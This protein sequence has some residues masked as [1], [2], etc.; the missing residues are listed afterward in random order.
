M[1]NWTALK[2]GD[3]MMEIFMAEQN[4]DQEYVSFWERIKINP[5]IWHCDDVI[6]DNFWVVAQHENYIIWYNDIEEGFCISKFKTEG[7]IQQY[8]ASKNE[9]NAVIQL[10]LQQF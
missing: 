4:L 8:T 5:V 3:L 9:L 1:E 2:K 10:F 6:E 7:K